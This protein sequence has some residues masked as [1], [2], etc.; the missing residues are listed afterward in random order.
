M[1]VLIYPCC[2]QQFLIVKEALGLGDS[3]IRYGISRN[4]T[5]D[6]HW[7]Y[8]I[9]SSLNYINLQLA[10]SLIYFRIEFQL[11]DSSF[12]ENIIDYQWYHL[13]V[14]FTKNC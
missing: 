12:D 13:S 14:I 4:Q 11:N 9:V 6:I 8:I 2:C 7:K 5:H 10:L 1:Y 3:Q